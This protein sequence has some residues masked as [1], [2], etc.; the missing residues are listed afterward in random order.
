MSP[1]PGVR[2][3]FLDRVLTLRRGRD[4]DLSEPAGRVSGRPR[5]G[6]RVDDNRS[7]P[8]ADGR[9]EYEIHAS[10]TDASV[11]AA[12]YHLSHMAWARD[13]HRRLPEGLVMRL[14]LRRAHTVDI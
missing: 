7:T 13:P 8:T 6:A 14:P 10:P 5:T 9:H 11:R 4:V 12:S 1:D 3:I 2:P